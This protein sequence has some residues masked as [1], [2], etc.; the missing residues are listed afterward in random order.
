MKQKMFFYPLAIFTAFLLLDLFSTYIGVCM[1][2]HIEIN[3]A[4]IKIAASYGF[5]MLFPYYMAERV[6]ASYLI[7]AWHYIMHRHYRLGIARPLAIAFMLLLCVGQLKMVVNNYGNIINELADAQVV[8]TSGLVDM[9]EQYLDVNVTEPQM[10]GELFEPERSSF[11]R[12][13]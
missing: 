3:D 11:C 10:I 13:I 7:W 5:L 1:L 12:L 8:D 9:P 2:G 4:A 6:I